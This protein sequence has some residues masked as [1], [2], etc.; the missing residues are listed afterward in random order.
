[1]VGDGGTVVE[2][3][4]EQIPEEVH[5]GEEVVEQIAAAA[6]DGNVVE[7]LDDVHGVAEVLHERWSQCVLVLL[8]QILHLSGHL[9]SQLADQQDNLFQWF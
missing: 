9:T 7:V 3:V 4:P 8:R 6:V 1:V 5:E 2:E